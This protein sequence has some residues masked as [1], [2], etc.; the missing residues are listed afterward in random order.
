MVQ[1]VWLPSFLWIGPAIAAHIFPSIVL[2][3]PLRTLIIRPQFHIRDFALVAVQLSAQEP[4][5][6][7]EMKEI[8]LP[9]KNCS[10]FLQQL[11]DID[12]EVSAP[13]MSCS[14]DTL[15]FLWRMSTW[16]NSNSCRLGVYLEFWVHVISTSYLVPILYVLQFPKSLSGIYLK[17]LRVNK[18]I[19]GELLAYSKFLNK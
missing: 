4:W 11:R 15:Q 18:Q 7:Q 3:A 9:D 8:L 6:C 13:C 2:F 14:E 5:L 10:S 12:D 19:V 1:N 16:W 17:S